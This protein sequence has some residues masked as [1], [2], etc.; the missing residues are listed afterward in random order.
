MTAFSDIS[1][2]A[3]SRFAPSP[4]GALHLGHAF[5]A[6]LAR[7]AAHRFLLRIEDIDGGRC[8]P[9]FVEAIYDDLNW[10]GVGWDG[11]PVIQSDRA[12]AH[13]AAL[14]RLQDMGLVYRC[15]CTRADIAAAAGAPQGEQPPLYPGTCRGRAA[16]EGKAF[17]WRLDMAK[18]IALA[19]PLTWHDASAGEIRATPEIFGDVVVARKDAGTS[20]HLAATVDDAAMGV[21]KIV[22]GRDLF[23]STHVHRLLQA[24]LDLPV[25]AY[26]HHPLIL[27]PD[28]KRLAKRTPGATLA[29]LRATG[30]DGRALAGDLRAGRLPVGFSF[31]R[32]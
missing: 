18:A 24:L 32:S 4:T 16:N 30:R 7:E 20:Y 6:V 17:S 11:E 21:T 27:G 15:T 2:Q 8:R 3:V 22:R 31:D 10:L 13:D 29:D 9:E 12:A 25:P 1:G 14:G 26:R 19:G 23:A 28:G 5:S